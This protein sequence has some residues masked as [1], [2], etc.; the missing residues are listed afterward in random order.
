[1][2]Q[3]LFDLNYD[4]KRSNNQ[5][6]VSE[7]Y[8]LKMTLNFNTGD[9]TEEKELIKETTEIVN[10]TVN[11]SNENEKI[12][13]EILLENKKIIVNNCLYEANK[14]LKIDFTK[15]FEKIKEYETDKKYNML[16]NL[17]SKSIPEVVGN[18]NVLF[19]FKNNFEVVLF[20]KNT[21]K[22]EKF[23]ELIY[24]KKYTVVS[25]SN[26]EWN[27]IR[28]KYINDIKNGVKYEYM[29]LKKMPRKNKKNT[30]L[31]NSIKD[32]FG[33]EYIKED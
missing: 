15:Q 18:N 24:N 8:F 10:K 14:Q 32:I 7:I 11:N 17:L 29:E 16:S 13:Q 19:T 22:I 9:K 3:D 30:E 20:E 21:E 1:M 2:S 25:V 5:K 33:E 31:E 26:E 27:E 23:I 12:E 4:L 6:I 28:T